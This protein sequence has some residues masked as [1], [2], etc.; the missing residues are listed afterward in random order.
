MTTTGIGAHLRDRR[1]AAGMS[2]RE[3]ARRS[4]IPQPNIA[5]YEIG[6]RVP[7]GATLE[8]L[9][10]TLDAPTLARL[11]RARGEILRAAHR[12]NLD[13]VRVFG[14]VARG[15]AGAGSDVDLLVHPDPEASVFDL[16]GFMAEVEELVGTRVD[17]VSDRGTGPAM[18]RIRD[19]AVAL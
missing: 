11:R 4:G 12:R 14:S 16:A 2:Q 17:V 1:R 15:E 5:A 13:D 7:T 6:R 3:L 8:R 9:D 19:E 18:D 10:A